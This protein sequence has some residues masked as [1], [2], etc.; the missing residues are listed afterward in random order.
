MKVHHYGVA[1]SDI[2]ESINYMEKIFT[3]QKKSAIVYDKNQNAYLCMLEIEDGTRIELVA[4]S[5]VER[6][7]KRRNYLYHICYEI[8]NMEQKIEEFIAMGAILIRTPQAAV[9]LENRR[10]AFL[11]TEIGMIE[12]LES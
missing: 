11:S 6:L 5:V 7:V 3:I 9:L 12:L 10:V 8:E 2:N 4:G 1:T